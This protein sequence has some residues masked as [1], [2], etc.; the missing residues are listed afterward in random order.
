MCNNLARA[1]SFQPFIRLCEDQDQ[2]GQD[3]VD[4]RDGAISDRLLQ[5]DVNI[6]L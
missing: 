6:V 5:E 4:F 3:R 1:G 2:E